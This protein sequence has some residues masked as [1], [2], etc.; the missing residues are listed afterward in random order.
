MKNTSSQFKTFLRNKI[1]IAIFILVFSVT[2]GWNSINIRYIAEYSSEPAY[3]IKDGSLLSSVDDEYY[4]TPAENLY[5]GNGLKR[6]PG[7]SSGDYYRRT[8]GYS[9]FYYSFLVLFDDSHDRAIAIRISQTALFAISA[10]VVYLILF[11][12]F[13]VRRRISL[14]TALLY[15]CI[16]TFSAYVANT[17]TEALTVPLVPVFIFFYFKY[18]NLRNARKRISGYYLLIAGLCWICLVMI[19]PLMGVLIL[20]PLIELGIYLFKKPQR[21]LRHGVVFLIFPILFFSV[22]TFRNFKIDGNI[23]VLEKVSHPESL[24]LYKPFYFSYVKI[25]SIYGVDHNISRRWYEAY[26]SEIVNSNRIKKAYK[27]EFISRLPSKLIETTR[28]D[29]LDNYLDLLGEII[30]MQKPYFQKSYPLPSN[31]SE[32]EL[33]FVDFSNRILIKNIE[34]NKFQYYLLSP[35][36]YLKIAV[37]HSNTSNIFLFQQVMRDRFLPFNLMRLGL[38]FFHI[39]LWL[40]SFVFFI[41]LISGKSLRLRIMLIGICPFVLLFILSFYFRGVE[42]RYLLPFLSLLLI[43]GVS[44]INSIKAPA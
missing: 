25:L 30:L 6:N 22:W 7:V 41:F 29:T 8:P 14:I 37:I 10:V 35:L 9:L 31:Y 11:K 12:L 27:D 32:K 26:K 24:D 3:S 38:A 2:W 13:E 28:R 4:V 34:V 44:T 1:E 33:K 16:P 15:G 23:V 20:I 42:Q 5:D 40:L 39:G 17:L 36:N 19:R 18:F 21:A 43:F